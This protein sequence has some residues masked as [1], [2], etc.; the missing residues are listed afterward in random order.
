MSEPE[1][2]TDP[3]GPKVW[4]TVDSVFGVLDAVL[5]EIVAN[6]DV[7]AKAVAWDTYTAFSRILG[8]HRSDYRESVNG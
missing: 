8:K 6:G 1:I 7:A 2:S 3:Q 4:V 5:R